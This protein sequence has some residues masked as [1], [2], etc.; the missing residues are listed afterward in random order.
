MFFFGLLGL[1]STAV[2]AVLL[3]WAG[4]TLW[5][6]LTLPKGAGKRPACEQCK[7]TVGEVSSFLCPECGS[8]LRRVGITTPRMEASRRGSTF[9]AIAAWTFLWLTAAYAITVLLVMMTGAAVFSNV[10]TWSMTLTPTRTFEYDSIELVYDEDGQWLTSV[11]TITMTMPD[12]STH[13]IRLDPGPMTVKGIEGEP[14]TWS[15]EAIKVWY[16]KI[17]LKLLDPQ[18]ERSANELGRVIDMM[19]AS[20]NA[21]YSLTTAEHRVALN[22]ISGAGAGGG[23]LASRPQWLPCGS[24]VFALAVYAGGAWWIVAR[25]RRLFHMGEE[26]TGEEPAHSST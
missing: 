16:R 6:A 12:K 20:P 8:D 4:H 17:G 2:G 13:Q 1:V 19:A 22:A 23:G 5:R 9:G 15:P 25:R 10:T 24:M 3:A 11:M 7:Y 26:H 18:I 14:I 21:M